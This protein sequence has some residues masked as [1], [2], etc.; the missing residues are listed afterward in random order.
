MNIMTEKIKIPKGYTKWDAADYLKSE[1]D[2][3]VFL[4]ECVAQDE[5][6][7]RLIR[8]ALADIAKAQ[9]VTKVAKK[10]GMSRTGIYKAL[11][12]EGNPEF[13]TILKIIRALGLKMDFAF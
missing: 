10:A 11:S 3:V 5:G 9:G 12:N 6:D 13:S 4:A 7:G 8:L 1:E 2:C